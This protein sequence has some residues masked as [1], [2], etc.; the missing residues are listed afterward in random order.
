MKM[1]KKVAAEMA[2]VM[3]FTAGCGAEES[4]S[5]EPVKEIVI[6][7]VVNQVK[8][9]NPVADERVIDD[10]AVENEMGLNPADLAEYEGIIT[11]SQ[12]DCALIFVAKTK[13]GKYKIFMMIMGEERDLGVFDTK[14]ECYEAFEKR[15]KEFIIK[16]AEKTKKKDKI[17]EC[18]Y[19]AMINWEV[20][21]KE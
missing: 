6:G 21:V 10:F 3:V 20:K 9:V 12:N 14:E 4:G 19:Q 16:L 2:A 11:N 7:D 15:K 8:E 13:E 18:Q 5:Q 17:P 1:M